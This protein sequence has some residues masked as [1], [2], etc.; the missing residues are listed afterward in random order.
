ML[1]S[2][3]VFIA[4]ASE[5]RFFMVFGWLSDKVGRKP[6]ILAGCLLAALTYFP[7][8]KALTAAT[9]PQLAA[10]SA[11]APVTV[12][13]DP[14]TCTFQFDPVGKATFTSGCDVAKS[15]LANAGVSSA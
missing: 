11:Y 6:V 15:A 14:A 1:T 13:A 7:I 12:V 4:L 3:L 2:K 9:N 5:T 10:A 8:F